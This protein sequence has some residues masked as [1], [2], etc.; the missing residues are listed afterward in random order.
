MRVLRNALQVGRIAG[1][2]AFWRTLYRSGRRALT[3][4]IAAR[5]DEASAYLLLV[6]ARL[7]RRRQ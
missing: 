6:R 5:L 2:G 7:L 1:P 4:A 3:R